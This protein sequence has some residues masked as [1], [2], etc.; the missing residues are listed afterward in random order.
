[1]TS[2]NETTS[3]FNVDNMVRELLAKG[4]TWRTYE[5]DLPYPGF[6]GLTYAN[7]VRRHNPLIDFTDACTTTQALNS[8]P[9]TQLA[10]DM[11]NNQVPNYSYITPNLQDDAHDGTLAQADLWLSQQMPAILARPEFLPGGDGL[12]FITFDEADL[13]TDNRCSSLISN[14][15]GGH[16]A[17]LII[18]PQVRPGYNSQVLYGPQNLLQ[19]VCDAMALA[20]CPGAGA[21]SLPMLDVFN[22]VSITGPFPGAAVA[23]PLAIH[24]VSQNN[25]TVNAMQ[26]YMDS[27]LAYGIIGSTLSTSLPVSS[28]MHFMVAQSWDAAGGIHKRSV[29][30]MVQSEAVVVTAPTPNAVVS[31]PF[32]VS[33]TAGGANAVSAMQVYVD[34]V[35]V[36]QTS[37]ATVNAKLTLN[38]G[39]H[40]V[41]VQ[42]W[43]VSGGITK[44]SF[45]V[46]V[47]TP[48]VQITSPVA[49]SLVISPVQF[50]ATSV[51]PSA[52]FAL[53]LY[54]DN[55]LVYQ[56]SGSGVSWPLALNVGPH[57][58]VAQV[59]DAA[60]GVYRQAVN[61]TVAVPLKRRDSERR[62]HSQPE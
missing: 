48:S 22:T 4:L 25:S 13:S 14:G 3:C 6:L 9:Y 47:A 56:T 33:A 43:D 2:D 52:V 34:N 49:N 44:N 32:S 21:V 20:V 23:S 51:D 45:Y 35:S 29:N 37:G 54:V 16:I 41:V 10:I 18:G 53:Q 15:C 11:A 42:A 60:G 38:A 36:Y 61:V 59:W 19:T 27:S 12:L 7:Y 8:V 28:G 30:V 50:V 24:A 31:S 46:T 17:T 5:E 1:V 57:T 26:L 39:L 40:N 62:R 55:T 58:I